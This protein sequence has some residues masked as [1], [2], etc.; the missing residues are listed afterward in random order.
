MIAKFIETK[1]RMVVTRS[2]RERGIGNS[3]LIGVEFLF[4]G[5][6]NSGDE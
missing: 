1:C 2:W 5:V 4:K 3:Y 6:K